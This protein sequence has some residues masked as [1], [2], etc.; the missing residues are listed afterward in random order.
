MDEPI[1]AAALGLKRGPRGAVCV[2]LL[3]VATP[4]ALVGLR[5]KDEG[6]APTSEQAEPVLDELTPLAPV[7]AQPKRS[8]T[9]RIVQPKSVAARQVPA[10]VPAVVESAPKQSE[11]VAPREPELVAVV[12]KQ[13]SVIDEHLVPPPPP[14]P[15]SVAKLE[16]EE[17]VPE[18]D[19]NGEAIARAI[20]A[21]KRAAVRACFES[22]LKASPKLHGTVIVELELAPPN[23]VNGVRVNDDLERAAFTSCVAA[24]MRD[25][26]FGALD[27]EISVSVPY[28]LTPAAK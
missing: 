13:E 11:R 5:S 6:V 27:E 15:E 17:E 2:A 1:D 7:P 12:E 10:P 3:L 24:T 20:A 23:R 14:P 4:L 16:E 22:E 28:V 21:E 8:R 25:V 9:K 26:K 19:G 18:R